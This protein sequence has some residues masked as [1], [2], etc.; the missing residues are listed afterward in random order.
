[1]SLSARHAL[2][3]SRYYYECHYATRTPVTFDPWVHFGAGAPHSVTFVL[4]AKSREIL[5]KTTSVD[6]KMSTAPPNFQASESLSIHDQDENLP[7]NVSSYTVAIISWIIILLLKMMNRQLQSSSVHILVATR[8]THASTVWRSMKRLYM[9]LW[10]MKAPRISCAHWIVV[11]AR[12]VQTKTS[13]P[14]VRWSTMK[15]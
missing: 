11:Y 8:V 6:T 1:M 2:R 5:K 13:F 15:S 3:R 9:G 7:E 10:L 12:S 4:Y 14:T